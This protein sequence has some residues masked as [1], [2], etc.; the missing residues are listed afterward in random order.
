MDQALDARRYEFERPLALS[1]IDSGMR[2][3]DFP[4]GGGYLR[5]YLPPDVEYLPAETVADY[6]AYAD[7]LLCDWDRIPL[8]SDSVD[9]SISIAA[10]H[11]LIHGR[12]DCYREIYRLTRPGGCFVIADVAA[13]SAPAAWLDEFVGTQ[14]SEGHV[15]IFH[16]EHEERQALTEAGFRVA[17]CRIDHYPWLFS[18]RQQTI[19]FCRGLFRLDRPDDELIWHALNDYLGTRVATDGAVELDWSLMLSKAVKD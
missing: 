1:G 13:D 12:S 3:L 11:H 7:V 15:A 14:S 8:A 2:L 17:A 5:H 9:V 4:S 18:S 6:A 16:D 19:D 10:L